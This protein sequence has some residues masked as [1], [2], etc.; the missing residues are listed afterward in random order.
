M[1][2]EDWKEKSSKL[3]RPVSEEQGKGRDNQLEDVTV[4]PNQSRQFA[5]KRVE[6]TKSKPPM[7]KAN[8]NLVK[9]QQNR[10]SETVSIRKRDEEKLVN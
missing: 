8:K 7:Q 2:F 1:S 6:K 5:K 10:V 4:S 3:Q 9:S